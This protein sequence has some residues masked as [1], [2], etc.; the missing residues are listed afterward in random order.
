M[1]LAAL[2]AT[3]AIGVGAFAGAASSVRGSDST[4]ITRATPV[5]LTVADRRIPGA[6]AVRTCAA[7]GPRGETRR[8]PRGRASLRNQRWA[9]DRTRSLLNPEPADEDRYVPGG[10][11]SRTFARSEL[12]PAIHAPRCRRSRSSRPD[13][14]DESTVVAAWLGSHEAACRASAKLRQIRTSTGARQRSPPSRA[15]TG[16]PCMHPGARR[17]VPLARV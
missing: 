13:R 3:G 4:R 17:T 2:L 11:Q 12:T 7:A 10:D 6:R 15:N 14:L 5:P 1:K 16:G 9:S 8:S